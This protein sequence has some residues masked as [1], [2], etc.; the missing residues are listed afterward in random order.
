[1]SLERCDAVP[2]CDNGDW[3]IHCDRYVGHAGPHTAVLT[4]INGEAEPALAPEWRRLVDD[5]KQPYRSESNPLGLDRSES[6]PLGLVLLALSDLTTT[7][8]DARG[9]DDLARIVAVCEAQV[10]GGWQADPEDD[11]Y[12]CRDAWGLLIVFTANAVGKAMESDWQDLAN[13]AAAWLR[14]I[15]EGGTE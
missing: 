7:H 9:L 15:T 8:S 11:P 12:G 6:N 2:T 13:A 4:Y 5:N 10:G 3:T 1:M 14:F